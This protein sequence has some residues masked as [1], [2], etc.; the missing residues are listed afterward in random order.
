MNIRI[1]GDGIGIFIV[2]SVVW[3]DKHGMGSSVDDDY[4]NWDNNEQ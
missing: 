3:N 2:E 1:T 4:G